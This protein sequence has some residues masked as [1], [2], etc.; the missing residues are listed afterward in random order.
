MKNNFFYTFLILISITNFSN[1]LLAQSTNEKQQALNDYFETIIKDTTQIIYVAKEK[2]NSNETLNIFGLNE[3]LIVDSVG[4]WKSDTTLYKKKTFNKMKKEYENSCKPGKRVLWC[5][6][7]YWSKDNFR[8]KK[9]AL[10]SMNTNKEIELILDKYNR[11]D[12]KVYGF[13]EPI[14]YETKRYIIFTMHIS[15]MAGA[16][17]QIIIMQKIKNKWI[18]THIGS[19]PNII[20]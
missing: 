2:I 3:I 18:V 5:N 12:I 7:D 19:N 17:T 20:N 9:V 13:S 11:A 15:H 8:Y 10:E 1:T 6:N 16:S 14:Y 4:N